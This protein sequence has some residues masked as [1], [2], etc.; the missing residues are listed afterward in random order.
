MSQKICELPL[1]TGPCKG[2]FPRFYFDTTSR[3]CQQFTYGGC[4]GN[5]NN[6]LN[7]AD[8]K[9]ACGHT[10]DDD[11]CSLPAFTGP[12]KAYFKRFYFDKTTGS[13]EEFVYGGC[14]SNGNNFNT[15]EECEA[16]CSSVNPCNVEQKVGPCK[17]AFN[18]YYYDKG[19]GKCLL[20]SWG[21]CQPNENNFL[22]L[23]DCRKE[24]PEKVTTTEDEVCS[25]PA[26]NGPCEA[27]FE[28]YYFDKK[29][30]WGER[31]D[32]GG[33][34]SN[35]NN[36]N[37]VEEC[38]AKCS[39]VNPCNVEQK[40]GPCKGAFNRYYY[41]KNAGK[42][43]LFSWGGCQPNENNFLTLED[44]QK[45]CPEKPTTTEDEVC[46]LPAF[47]G[48]CKA[49]FKRFYFDKTTG[50][51]EE[52]VYGGC[53]SNGNNFNTVEEC[54]AK[55]SSVNPCNVEK[56]VGPCRAAINRYYYDKDAGECLLFSWG[57]CEPNENNFLT[58][59]D[60]EKV[61]P[62]VKQTTKKQTTKVYSGKNAN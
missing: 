15:A 4:G 48:P 31:F 54:E 27:Y 34:Q 22:T 18:R 14:Q 1:V 62:K 45:V 58:L 49:Y 36:F 55:C 17:G 35:G 47:T 61:C 51:C 38:E 3:T 40:V 11:V 37:T 26:F 44:C 39:T 52:F 10:N 28:R 50:S 2:V 57:G 8:C 13:C 21:G 6:F 12:C 24:C 60:C 16:K 30:G 9:K 20:F 32:G 33:C 56:K 19:A 42:C 59:E 5:M 7:L 23:E 41:E 29:T 46:S 43:L 25:L 53:Q